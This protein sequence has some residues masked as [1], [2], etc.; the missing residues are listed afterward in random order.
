MIIPDPK[1]PLIPGAGKPV[2]QEMAAA[3]G[4]RPSVF[5]CPSSQM[6]NADPSTL[7]DRKARPCFAS[8]LP[9]IG[10]AEEFVM[11]RQTE[12]CQPSCG[13]WGSKGRPCRR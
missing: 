9:I 11:T 7:L 8:V 2:T 1:D 13:Y 10:V 12:M 6:E 3:A 5:K 4:T